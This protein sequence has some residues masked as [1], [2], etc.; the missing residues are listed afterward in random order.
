LHFALSERD[1]L[2]VFGVR[3]VYIKVTTSSR[4]ALWHVKETFHWV[5]ELAFYILKRLTGLKTALPRAKE[6]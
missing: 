4:S 3:H 1:T 2:A 5:L 6:T